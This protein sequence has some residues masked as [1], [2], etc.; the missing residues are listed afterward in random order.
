MSC[1]QCVKSFSASKKYDQ[2]DIKSFHGTFDFLGVKKL[3]RND[4]Q[5]K[6]K[7]MA[8]PNKRMGR[9]RAMCP[10]NRKNEDGR[11]NLINGETPMFFK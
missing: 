2:N 8:V 10:S 1:V 7:N 3:E 11:H 5:Q 6:L 4:H 9:R